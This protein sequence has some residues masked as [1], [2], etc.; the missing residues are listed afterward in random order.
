MVR[1]SFGPPRANLEA[2]LDRLAEMI[3]SHRR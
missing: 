1:F 3:K 2:G